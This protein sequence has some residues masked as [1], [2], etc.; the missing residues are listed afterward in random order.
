L[1]GVF[2][3]KFFFLMCLFFFVGGGGGGG[4]GGGGKPTLFWGGGLGGGGV[5]VEWWVG[6]T[7]PIVCR[8]VDRRDGVGQR[9]KRSQFRWAWD[10]GI[11]FGSV[12]RH[13]LR[14]LLKTQGN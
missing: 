3:L 6:G 14:F 11:G 2:N 13:E 1:G 4:V 8:K 7:K 10:S 12:G 5:G 9:A